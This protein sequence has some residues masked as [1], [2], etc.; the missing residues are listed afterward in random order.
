VLGGEV[1]G[2][3]P[4]ADFLPALETL[5]QQDVP[6]SVSGIVESR[7]DQDCADVA[8]AFLVG[9]VLGDRFDAE[10]EFGELAFGAHEVQQDGALLFG[11]EEDRIGVRHRVQDSAEAVDFFGDLVHRVHPEKSLIRCLQNTRRYALA[12]CISA[13]Q[14]HCFELWISCRIWPISA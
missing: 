1:T 5:G 13:G 7:S 6:V 10:S 12:Q 2:R 14:T 3:E 4:G 11:G 8:G 9:E